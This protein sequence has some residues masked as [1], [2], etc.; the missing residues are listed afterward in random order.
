MRNET[1]AKPTHPSVS[2]DLNTH[3][4]P[5]MPTYR[6]KLKSH[7]N[8]IHVEADANPSIGDQAG[9]TNIILIFKRGD[10]IVAQFQRSDVAGWWHND[11]DQTPVR[12]RSSGS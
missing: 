9:Y 11:D 5:I 7:D 6:V 12:A 3:R 8:I 1:V 4:S 2:F 10:E